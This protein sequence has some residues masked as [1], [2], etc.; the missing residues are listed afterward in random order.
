MALTLI[1]PPSGLV[2]S[3]VEIKSHL[4]IDSGDFDSVLEAYIRAATGHIDGDTWFGRALIPQVWD[5]IYDVFPS[6]PIEIPLSPLISIDNIHYVNEDGNSVLLD[7]AEYE[8]DKV[9]Q[10]GWVIPGVD[11]PWPTTFDSANA[12]QIR[13][14]AGYENGV[15]EDIKQAIKLVVGYWFT[16]RESFSDVP[17]ND[18]PFFNVKALLN[19]HRVFR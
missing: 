5:L 9:S 19:N 7:S 15:P 10:P 13:F 8:V 14:T 18:F 2:V 12:V 11:F 1:T 4:N 6:G 16:Q 3:T 17:V